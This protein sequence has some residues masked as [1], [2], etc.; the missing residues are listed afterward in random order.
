MGTHKT[1]FLD[2]EGLY[3]IVVVPFFLCNAIGGEL[4]KHIEELH[5]KV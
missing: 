3:D 4:Q 1:A 5:Y 2:N